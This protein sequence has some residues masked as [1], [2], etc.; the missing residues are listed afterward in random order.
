M[1]EMAHNKAHFNP[2]GCIMRFLNRGSRALALFLV[3]PVLAGWLVLVSSGS[4]QGGETTV[5]IGSATVGPGNSVTVGLTVNPGV[6]VIVGALD[7]SLNFDSSVIDATGCTVLPTGGCNSEFSSVFF[8][9]G[10]VSGLSGLEATATFQAVGEDGASSPLDLSLQTC[11][12]HTG[13]QIACTAIDGAISIQATGP[14]PTP[15]PRATDFSVSPLEIWIL[16]QYLVAGNA[17]F[18]RALIRN[19]GDTTETVD[20]LFTAANASSPEPVGIGS[21]LVI[22]PAGGV[23]VAN[24][25]FWHTNDKFGY[26]TITVNVD[27]QNYYAEPSEFDNTASIQFF[28]STR[29]GDVNCDRTANAVDSLAILRAIVG[30]PYNRAPNCPDIV[31]P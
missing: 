20:V 16:P 19:S 15:Q 1:I 12:D 27:P 23:T 21:N 25:P 2:W 11:K 22:V 26:N 9:I 24:T 4:S 8:S 17:T 31:L 13:A 28:V 18:I 14:T 29:W 10:D 6:G 30:L 7:I 3:L 5:S